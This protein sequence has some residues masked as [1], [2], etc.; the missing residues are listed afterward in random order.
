MKIRFL[1]LALFVAAVVIGC[2]SEPKVIKE[3]VTETV[4]KEREVVVPP[5]VPLTP[6]ILERLRKIDGFDIKKCQFILNGEI[7]LTTTQMEQKDTINESEGSA[8]FR[9]ILKKTTV[10]FPNKSPGLALGDETV[11]RDD[12]VMCVY[13]ESRTDEP[14]Y[15]A[16]THNLYFS[17]KKTDK[18]AYFRLVYD[19]VP[20]TIGEVKGLLEYG[21]SK[22]PLSFYWERPY[23]MMKLDQQTME[24][25]KDDRIVGPR[26]IK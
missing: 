6:A 5:D 15:P 2:P 24:I 8:V 26:K 22:Q 1:L 18:N 4:T 16:T 12:L 13:F 3:T 11:E 23:I 17:A 9:N 7:K 10:T 21:G 14:S 20:D 19:E 25:V